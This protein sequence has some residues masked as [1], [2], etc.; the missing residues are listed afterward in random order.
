MV[1]SKYVIKINV[2][3]TLYYYDLVNGYYVEEN[4]IEPNGIFYVENGTNEFQKLIDYNKNLRNNSN[5]MCITL[6]ITKECNFRCT[7]CFEEHESKKLNLDSIDN[8][9]SIIR[10]YLTQ[11]KQVNRIVVI[12]FGGEPTMY[13]DYILM[14]NSMLKDIS[15]DMDVVYSSRIITNGFLL[16]KIIPY[17]SELNLTD[18]QIT[19]DGPKAIHDSR[20]KNIDGSGSFDTIIENIQLIHEKIDLVVRANVDSKNISTIYELYHFIKKLNLDRNVKLYFQPML[21]ENYGG[22]SECYLSKIAQDEKL[23]TEYIKLLIYTKSLDKPRFIRAFCNVDFPGSLVVSSNA[24]LYKCWAATEKKEKA[25][26]NINNNALEIVE[27]MCDTNLKL[28]SKNCFI[29]T[30]F[31]VCMGGC[32]YIDFSKDE[33]KKRQKLIIEEVKYCIRNNL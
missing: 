12:W 32:K 19:F 18:I 24:L 27:K 6:A 7:Y 11:N 29:C 5:F 16:N 3:G 33:C 9:N 4:K 2:D 17:I 22:E 10:N 13:I 26:D 20:R 30:F 28:K 23:Y 31:P 25:F 1:L 14:A 15:S 8:L 21:V